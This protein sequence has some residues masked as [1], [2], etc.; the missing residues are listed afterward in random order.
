MLPSALIPFVESGL[1]TI[2]GTVSSSGQPECMRGIGLVTSD[3]GS[4]ARVFL[5]CDT[6]GKTVENLRKTRRIA[7]TVSQPSTHRTVQIKGQ[8]LSLGLAS[9]ADRSQIERLFGCFAQELVVIGLPP[10]ILDRVQRWPCWAADF[11]VGE[12]FVQTPGPRAGQ[13][14]SEADL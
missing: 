4:I 13:V 12:V 8:L 7:V 11:A 6:A 14:L 9:D 10:P 1:S 5:P 2:V 3:A